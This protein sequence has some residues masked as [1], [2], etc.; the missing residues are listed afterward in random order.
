[1]SQSVKTKD[2]ML[3]GLLLAMGILLPMFFHSVG[4]MGKIFLPMHIPVLIGGFILFPQLALF[5]G[6]VT[7]L[8]SGALTGMPIMFPM[9]VIMAFELG[10]YGLIVSLAVRK[11]K[12]SV[13]PS[14]IIAM[15]SG[16]IVAGIVVFILAQFF[17]LEM[18]PIFFIKG[19]IVTGFP[20]IGVQ[21]V[22]IPSIIYGLRGITKKKWIEG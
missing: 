3:S 9:A 2:L 12:L 14:L 4:I 16:R 20:G 10:T 7:P 22:M 1:M 13:M 5:L 15:I 17:G 19:A 11:M 6:M 21:L 8:V 18:N